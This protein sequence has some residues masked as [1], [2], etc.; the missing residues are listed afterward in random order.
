MCTS[1]LQNIICTVIVLHGMCSVAE[2]HHYNRSVYITVVTP[3][4]LTDGDR[5]D[6]QLCVYYFFL[7]SSIILLLSYLALHRR[8]R[9]SNCRYFRKLKNECT[10][11]DNTGNIFARRPEIHPVGYNVTLINTLV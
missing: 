6:S 10:D 3:S 4:S 2:L 9:Y 8:A 1:I 11:Q 7:I 5:S